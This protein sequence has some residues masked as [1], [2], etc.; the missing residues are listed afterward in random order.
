MMKIINI[1]IIKLLLYYKND[2]IYI[3]LKKIT[4]LLNY[5]T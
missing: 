2:I 1:I 3:L 5:Y 4:R